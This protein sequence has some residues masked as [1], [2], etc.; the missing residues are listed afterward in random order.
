M[1]PSPTSTHDVLWA[2]TRAGARAGRGFRYQD[3]AGAWL[4]AAAWSG[5]LPWTVVIPEGLDDISLHGE[6]FELRAQLKSRH[7]AQATFSLVE[8]ADYLAKIAAGLSENDEQVAVA[9][10]LERGV[11]GLEPSGWLTPL[12]A[13]RQDLGALA[14]LLGPRLTANCAPGALLARTYLIV[15]P[16]PLERAI[17]TLVA[18]TTLAPARAR[19]LAHGLRHRAGEAAD[20]NF[21][22]TAEAAVGL[23]VAT[24]QD[25]IDG[26]QAVVDPVGYAELTGGL[27]DLADFDAPLDTGGFYSGVDVQPGHVGAGLVF[28]RPE[29]TES[30]FEALAAQRCALVAG[31][32]G[33]GKSAIA[34][35]SA[36]AMRHVVR[37]YRVRVLQAEDVG[38]LAQ[39]ARLLEATAARPVGFVVDDVG[40][41]ATAGWDVLVREVKATPVL[42]A[43]GTVRE[44]DVLTLETG[45][46]TRV[47]RP[48]LDET[49]AERIFRALAAENEM[50]FS[51]W[52]EPLEHSGGLLLEYTHLLTAG[53]RLGETLGGQVRRRLVENRSDE[54]L[55]LEVVA[56]LSTHGGSATPKGLR[57][58]LGIGEI[59]F[60]RAL[61]RL[62]EEHALRVQA[63]GTLRGLHEIRSRH[64]DAAMR[65]MLARPIGE[66]TRRALASARA[67]DFPTLLPRLLRAWPNA[68]EDALDILGER[69][70]GGDVAEHVA[71]LR[72]L[73]LATVDR[74]A[75][76]WVEITRDVGIDDR[77]SAISL[78]FE[79]AESDLDQ[80]IFEKVKAAAE[81]FR[82]E[83][84]VDLRVLLQGRLLNGHPVANLGLDDAHR[85]LSASLPFHA[86]KEGPQVAYFADTPLEE[87]PLHRLLPFLL[88]TH[89]AAPDLGRRA[90]ARAG[91]VDHLL[92]RIWRETDW[93]TRPIRK[94][95]E[96]QPAV[97]S[98]I[99]VTDDTRQTDLHGEAVAHCTRL[100]AADPDAERLLCAI[101]TADGEPAGFGGFEVA[102][103][104]MERRWAIDPERVAWNRAHLRAVE[105]IV[106]ADNETGREAAFALAVN[107]LEAK[108]REAGDFYCRMEAAP[109]KWR[110]FM[111]VRALLTSF[112]KPPSVQDVAPEG[113]GD[114]FKGD[115]LHDLVAGLQTLATELAD[116]IDKPLLAA[117]Q[118]AELSKKVEALQDARAWRWTA[119][120][121]FSALQNIHV[122]LSDLTAVLEDTHV[123]AGRRRAA[124][125]RLQ[126]SSRKYSVLHRASEEARLRAVQDHEKMRRNVLEACQV[127][128]WE[129]KVIAREPADTK[130]VWP[131]VEFGIFISVSSVA[132]WFQV[133]SEFPAI[134]QTPG[135][136]V[137]MS[138]ILVREDVAFPIG[139]DWRG[140]LFPAVD[141]V[142][143]WRDHSPVPFLQD[144]IVGNFTR[145]IEWLVRLSAMTAGRDR[146]L[147]K[148]EEVDYERGI[149]E[150]VRAVEPLRDLLESTGDSDLMECVEVIGGL[151]RRLDTEAKE[152]PEGP[153]LAAELQAITRGE[154]SELSWLILGCRMTLMERALRERRQLELGVREG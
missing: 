90:V 41:D 139:C 20:A 62:V 127:R 146:S 5:E 153:V 19:L 78:A 143:Q 53:Q 87:L 83:T 47:I 2:K 137:R 118:A 122:H 68:E 9:I 21:S 144:D 135:P 128:G 64:L 7:D 73:G 3:A 79:L 154:V 69:M 12:A 93:V 57:N 131:G 109:P 1:R 132:D 119:E 151:I 84:F 91:G 140:Q 23:D 4:A 129:V 63:D 150:L 55:I 37:W 8:V 116:P 117:H 11:D 111:Q 121:P 115:G 28:D 70:R 126:K 124:A 66:L 26:V 25:E 27:C 112:V 80:P 32:S 43:I 149:G 22:A 141:P 45:G 152:A 123:D 16:A 96:G 29:T 30:V 18:R 86:C 108:L 24:V 17:E 110:L 72:G 50:Q 51:H 136:Y 120:P 56:L 13:T 147:N 138:F 48:R 44:E 148:S 40:R 142:G 130:Y 67:A 98:N 10:V 145:A 15:E 106:A 76:R 14:R 99:R 38:K 114:G 77:L 61:A 82:A 60:A 133:L 6:S 42:L 71:I 102:T 52:R 59:A 95:Y 94:D 107:E 81:L 33:A 89:L 36:F 46:Q 134:A 58:V 104:K 125:L 65:E 85:L 105:R 101:V 49:L 39:L 88:T 92:E 100:A 35:M 75:K 31:P 103:K 97:E 54:L 34:W 74:I 113:Q